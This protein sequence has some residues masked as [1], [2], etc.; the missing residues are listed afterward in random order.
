IAAKGNPPVELA[1]SGGFSFAAYFWSTIQVKPYP[2]NWRKLLESEIKLVRPLGFQRDEI[3]LAQVWAAEAQ[4]NP[5]PVQF[6][7]A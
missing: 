6:L 5:S 4:R 7:F 1:R 2:I 3:P